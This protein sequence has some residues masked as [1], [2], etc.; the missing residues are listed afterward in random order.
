MKVDN[1]EFYDKAL[2]LF[3]QDLENENCRLQ[4]K[5]ASLE[6]IPVLTRFEVFWLLGGDHTLLTSGRSC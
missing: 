2:F 1:Y 3:A 6:G 4:Q 5:M